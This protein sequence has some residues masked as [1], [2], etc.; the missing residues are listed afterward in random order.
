M[1]IKR[2]A[3]SI[4]AAFLVAIKSGEFSTAPFVAAFAGKKRYLLAEMACTDGYL[5]LQIPNVTM[6]LLHK[7]VELIKL[8]D[9]LQ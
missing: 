7:A 9:H 4:L 1:V 2:C 6:R 5:S 8:P 3:R